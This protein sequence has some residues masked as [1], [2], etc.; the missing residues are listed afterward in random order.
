MIVAWS[1]TTVSPP[2]A[3]H[4]R[5]FAMAVEAVKHRHQVAGEQER[6]RHAAHDH[7][8]Q[9]PLGLRADLRR[10]RRGQQAE[11]AVSAVIITGRTRFSAPA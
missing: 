8:R 10:K 2:A 11:D 7:D 3:G 4:G 9:R 1:G 6:C 5:R